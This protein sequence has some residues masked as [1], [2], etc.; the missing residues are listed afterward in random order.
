MYSK[1]QGSAAKFG[2]F[3]NGELWNF[4]NCPAEFGKIFPE[5]LWALNITVT[6]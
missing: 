4:P 5:K 1:S 2:Q 3:F 6:N